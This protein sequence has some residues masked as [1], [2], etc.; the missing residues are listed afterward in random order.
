MAV[1]SCERNAISRALAR[2]GAAAVERVQY[3]RYRVTSTSRPGT[4][5]TVSVDAAGRYLWGAKNPSV[6]SVEVIAVIDVVESAQHWPRT[7][8]CA[9]R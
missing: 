2:G 7:E 5:H 1:T 6:S 3:G 4:V 8:R 9:T